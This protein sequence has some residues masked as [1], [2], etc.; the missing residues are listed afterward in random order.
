M[1]EK[2]K[3]P[4]RPSLLIA[5]ALDD[6]ELVIQ[7][8]RYS[9]GMGDWHNPNTLDGTC[10]VCLA[11]AVMAKTFD[12]STE[13]KL[14]PHNVAFDGRPHC[15]KD[16]EKLEALDSFRSGHI[17]GGMMKSTDLSGRY[18]ERYMRIIESIGRSVHVES[19]NSGAEKFIK[20]MDNLRLKLEAMGL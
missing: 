13:Q 10:M 20:D 18:G 3:L 9:I 1:K 19:F 6:L 7:D 15:L 14:F 8:P 2:S 4:N 5:V 11:G 17:L 12:V 16:V